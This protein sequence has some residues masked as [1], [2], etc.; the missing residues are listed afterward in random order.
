MNANLPVDFN[1][2][3][4]VETRRKVST[5][6]A[7]ARITGEPARRSMRRLSRFFH[8][9][10]VSAFCLGGWAVFG[11]QAFVH[12][13][14]Y[15][16]RDDLVFLQ[17]R[18][19]SGHGPTVS[20][21]APLLA[22]ANLSHVPRP[23]EVWDVAKVPYMDG[24]A[25]AAW[26]H[27]LV[28]VLTGKG[29]HA[30]KSIEILGAW[31]GK[32]ESIPVAPNSQEMLVCAWN[33]NLLAN[34]A[35]ILK[36]GRDPKGGAAGWEDPAQKAFVSMAGLMVKILKPY[37]SDYNG[38]WDATIMNSLACFAV[39]LEDRE[40][41]QG[42]VAHF[43]G[44][45][46]PA[47]ED[48]TW[49]HLAKYVLP[50]GQCQEAGRDWGHVQMGLGQY[51]SV[52]E[53]AWKQGVD[54][55]GHLDNRLRLGIEYAA[56][57][58]LGEEVSFESIPGLNWPTISIRDRGLFSPIY[59]SAYRHYVGRRGLAMPWT[60]KVLKGDGVLMTYRRKTPGAYRP[61]ASLPNIGLS[62]GTL[63]AGREHP[64]F[65]SDSK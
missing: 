14:L 58:M 42:V 51:L 7:S 44:E 43:K 13:G 54:L 6:P 55:Y 64:D 4:V 61:E 50:S 26:A 28:W 32:L 45:Y 46:E 60:E 29:E 17:S 19:A 65:H 52:C 57:Y 41:F 31:S 23:Q 38:N 49:G 33:G 21:M 24:D 53:V 11:A 37:K 47:R 56:R 36:Y 39:H 63:L 48:L 2:A 9:L 20:A 8:L 16:N 18:L 30:R 1:I 40:V 10:L 27:A 15:V 59:E 62:F 25:M 35:E 22:A 12:P 5:W 3:T 34:A